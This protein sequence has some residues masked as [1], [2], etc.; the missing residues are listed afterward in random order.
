MRG[1]RKRGS[2]LSQTLPACSLLILHTTALP[3]PVGPPKAAPATSLQRIC[4]AGSPRPVSTPESSPPTLS[5]FSRELIVYYGPPKLAQSLKNMGSQVELER[6]RA[7]GRYG[8]LVQIEN[9]TVGVWPTSSRI[10]LSISDTE[11]HR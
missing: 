9:V 2:L 6:K 5:P 10:L 1:A 4:K 11:K 8:F 3:W 7:K